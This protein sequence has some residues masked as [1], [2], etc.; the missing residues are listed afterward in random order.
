MFV[1]YIVSLYQNLGLTGGIPLIL[2]ASYVTVAT[3]ANLGGALLLD[4]V[5]RKPLLSM[6]PPSIM[7]VNLITFFHSNWFG[8]LYGVCLPRNGNDRKLRR[9]YK[10]CW[11]RYGRGLLVLFHYLLRSGN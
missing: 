1:V 4:K 5:G 3:L 6:M 7:W 8:R 2:G 10:P 11:P 9:N